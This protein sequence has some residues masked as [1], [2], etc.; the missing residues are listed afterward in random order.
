[1]VL[2]N[3]PV[4]LD[5]ERIH[6]YTIKHYRVQQNELNPCLITFLEIANHQI[7]DVEEREK[8]SSLM[9]GS[10]EGPLIKSCPSL[11]HQ[12]LN[13]FNIAAVNRGSVWSVVSSCMDHEF[14]LSFF[15]NR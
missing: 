15:M 3:P 11:L 2:K 12:P 8:V 5:M 13:S 7:V 1:M 14:Q 6:H 9:D 10:K 4:L